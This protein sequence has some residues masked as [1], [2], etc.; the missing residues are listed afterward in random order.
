MEALCREK[1]RKN[2]LFLGVLLLVFLS[3][4]IRWELRTFESA[5]YSIFLKS[6]YES[7]KN[8]GGLSGLKIEIGDYYIPY[9][10]FLALF[11]YI[12]VNP[13]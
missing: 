6:W 7:L 2:S 1:I 12:P 9:L 11:T 8:S 5:D 3:I 4:I 10:A 13:L